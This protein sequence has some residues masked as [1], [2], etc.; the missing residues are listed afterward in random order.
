MKEQALIRLG[1]NYNTSGINISPIDFSSKDEIKE[2]LD[3]L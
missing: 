3:A 1:A 2:Y